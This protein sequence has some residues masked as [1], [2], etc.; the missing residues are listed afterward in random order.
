MPV[1]FVPSSDDR[2]AVVAVDSFQNLMPANSEASVS[3]ENKE[4]NFRSWL[5]LLTSLVATVTFTAGLTPPG[6]LWSTDDDK[7]KKYLAGDPVIINKSPDRYSVFYTSNTF[8][9]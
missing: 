1:L 7:D 3:N 2:L 8:A 4:Q 9:F 6:G 5:L